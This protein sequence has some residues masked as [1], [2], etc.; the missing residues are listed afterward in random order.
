M[1]ALGVALVVEGVHSEFALDWCTAAGSVAAGRLLVPQ[2][3]RGR[4]VVAKGKSTV[5][6]R[7]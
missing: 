1:V 7:N 4:T 6:G 3:P 2:P 5:L